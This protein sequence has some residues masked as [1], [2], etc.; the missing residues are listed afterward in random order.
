MRESFKSLI[1]AKLVEGEKPGQVVVAEPGAGRPLGAPVSEENL[2]LIVGEESFSSQVADRLLPKGG[3]TS[4]QPAKSLFPEKT[5]ELLEKDGELVEL[6]ATW[7]TNEDFLPSAIKILCDI[8]SAA[9][10]QEWLA[11]KKIAVA[12]ALV[13][14]QLPPRTLP[15]SQVSP[16]SLPSPESSPVERFRDLADAHNKGLLLMD[17]TKLSVGEAFFLVGHRIPVSEL[18]W[19]RS[20]RPHGNPQNLAESAFRGVRYSDERVRKNEYVWGAAPYTMEN[21]LKFGGICIDQAYYADVMCKASGIPSMVFAGAGDAGGHAWVGYLSRSGK[22][23]VAVG[24][25]GGLYLTGKTYNP[26]SWTVETDHEFGLST[27][28]SSSPARLE[29]ALAEIF[30]SGGNQKLSAAAISAATSLS[31][32]NPRV[33]QRKFAQVSAMGNPAKAAQEFRAA[34]KSRDITPEVR[35]EIKRGLASAEKEMGRDFAAEQIEKDIVKENF[36]TRT[37][38][39]IQQLAEKIK[40]AVDAGNT[41]KAM[42]SYRDAARR[43]PPGSRGDFFYSVTRPLA[44]A[45]MEKGQRAE[46]I[47]TVKLARQVIAPPKGSLIENDIAVLEKE[48]LRTPSKKPAAS[49]F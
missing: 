4:P 47:Q 11:F 27:A 48:A 20:H 22:W 37:D 42:L 34:L 1:R 5:M 16:D 2:S 12:L 23:D 15:H 25:S 3:W 18:Q 6:L 45:L 8:R 41:G 36:T 32:D 31:P 21:I 13:D 33:W 43:L 9:S 38:I 17:I 30:A 40:L 28:E 14:D 7:A 29:M 39:S 10:P 35:A 46:A 19:A 26:Q 24:R 44:S 49:R